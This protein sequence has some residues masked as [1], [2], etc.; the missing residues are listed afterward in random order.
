MP[1]VSL[2]NQ[3]ETKDHSQLN[4][5][6]WGVYVCSSCGGVVTAWANDWGAD[7]QQ[8]FPNSTSVS[9]DV[10]EKPRIYL[11]QAND[12][13]HAPAG[14]VMLSASAVDAMLKFRGLGEGSLYKRI[15]LAIEQNILT[16][17]MGE[18]AHEVRLDAND[19]RHADEDASLP[20]MEDARR[21][22]DYALALAEFLFILP[23]RV[24]RGISNAKS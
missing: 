12:S 23:N 11:Q 8:Y 4:Y 17:D 24:K 13:L 22:L 3:F 21:A 10:P 16:S 15:E 18:W 2:Y 7:V 19:Q 14:A 1:R 9:E 5:R 20:T 6:R